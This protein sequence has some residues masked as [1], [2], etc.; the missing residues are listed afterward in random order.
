M[1]Q[2]ATFSIARYTQ[3]KA[4]ILAREW[5]RRMQFWYSTFHG[6]AK[7]S[8]ASIDEA[9]LPDEPREF[10]DMVASEK[11]DS[12]VRFRGEEMR[13]LRPVGT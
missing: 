5:C 10:K 8:K 12:D 13:R 3:R 4:G 7:I 11:K 9:A 6:L 2:S 1:H